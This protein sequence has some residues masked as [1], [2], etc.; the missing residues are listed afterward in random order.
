MQWHSLLVQLSRLNVL[1]VYCMGCM[2]EELIVLARHARN[3]RML[4]L[5]CHGEQK[6][7][8]ASDGFQELNEADALHPHLALD[9]V[10]PAHLAE[11][12][13]ALCLRCAE[14]QACVVAQPNPG[15]HIHE[16]VAAGFAVANVL[17]VVLVDRPQH[18]VL[19][20]KLVR[21]GLSVHAPP[22]E[23]FADVDSAAQELWRHFGHERAV[24]QPLHR[25]AELEGVV[26]FLEEHE[27]AGA[28][29]GLQKLTLHHR[30]LVLHR[31]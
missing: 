19:L 28:H 11:H 9:L 31:L 29:Q 17:L 8:C 24:D 3:H 6:V 13:A 26:P 20:L 23:T 25:L 16:R 7:R 27:Q 10:H 30:I 2:I 18:A 4:L 1:P 5:R 22:E 14:A 12:E 21:N 15:L